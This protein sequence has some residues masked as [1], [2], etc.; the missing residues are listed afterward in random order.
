[1]QTFHYIR[2]VSQYT[3]AYGKNAVFSDPQAILQT[4]AMRK[5]PITDSEE[6][7]S[8]PVNPGEAECGPVNPGDFLLVHL[9]GAC[10]TRKCVAQAAK[11]TDATIEVTFLHATGTGQDVCVP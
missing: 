10:S 9:H 2:P 4:K 8:G 11:T 1:M 3:L 5:D 7:E 6:E